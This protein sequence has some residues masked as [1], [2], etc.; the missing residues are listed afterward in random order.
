MTNNTLGIFFL[1]QNYLFV[2]NKPSKDEVLAI[3]V[4]SVRNADVNTELKACFKPT[5]RTLRPFDQ[6]IDLQFIAKKFNGKFLIV[7]S[8]ILKH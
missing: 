2:Y 6:T 8:Q 3:Y 1:F 4:L 7:K 5:Y